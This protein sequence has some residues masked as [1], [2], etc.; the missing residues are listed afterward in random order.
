MSEVR[1]SVC[2]PTR[3]YGAYIGAAIESVLEQIEPGVEIVVLDSGSSDNTREIVEG[4]AARQACVRYFYQPEPGGIDRDM[5][6]SVELAAGEHCWLLSAD[7]ALAPGA[8][9]RILHEFGAG[10]DLLLANRWWCDARLTPLRR[11]TWLSGANEDR[12]VDFSAPGQALAYLAA[13]RSV[14]ALFSFMSCIGFRREHWL[15]AAADASLIG[16]HYAHIQRLFAVGRSGIRLCYI[17]APLILC[18]GG[19]DSFRA[20]GLAGRLLID[21]RGFLAVGRSVFPDSMALQQAF[22]AVLKRE[23]ALRRWA[24]AYSERP[25][26][27]LWQDVEQLLE[28]F[29]Y[30]SLE[31]RLIRGAGSLLRFAS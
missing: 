10:N 24:R 29:G 25:D 20:G 11:E 22:F 3:N 4:H 26:R 17:D 8:L 31:R 23:H 18:R 5:A 30:S 1:L 19:S 14:G 15:C 7:D 12:T 13:A 9:K 16:T 27:D 2:M 6:R 28:L 21:L